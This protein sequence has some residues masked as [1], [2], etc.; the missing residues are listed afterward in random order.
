MKNWKIYIWIVLIYIAMQFGSLPV[1]RSLFT[2]FMDTGGQPKELAELNAI[3]WGLFISNL[4]AAPFILYMTTRNKQF[5]NFFKKGK[6]ASVG[7]TILFGVLGFFMAMA[8]QMIGGIIEMAFGVTPGSENTAMLG[9]IAK[10]SYILII[11]IVIFAPL[12]EEIIFR[13]VLFGGLYTKTNFW[14]AALVSAAL[15]SLVHGEPQHLLIYMAPGLV[16]AFI[17]Y[18]TQRIWAPM[19]AH[20]LMNSFAM[21]VQFNYDKLMELQ[22]MKQAFIY[23]LS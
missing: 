2:Y 1:S 17:Y 9:E 19:I 7:K 23:F 3:A 18:V 15:F 13:R 10:A 20:F 22:N 8:G 16:F 14:I 5:W 12:L 21:V 6:K 4:V 11:P